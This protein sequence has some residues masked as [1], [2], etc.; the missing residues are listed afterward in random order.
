[1]RITQV[2]STAVILGLLWWHSDSTTPKGLQDQAGLLFFISVFWGFFPVFTAIFTFPQEK[3]MLNKE[4]AVDMY[5]LSAYFMART[6]SDLPL[7]LVLPILFLVIVY[8]MA[9]LR[10]AAAPFLLSMLIVFLSIIAAQGLG[11]A[12]GAIMMD[13]KKATTLGSVTVMAFMLAGGFFVKR[14]PEFI[15]WVRYISFNYHTYRLLLKV[16]YGSHFHDINGIHLDNGVTE[17]GAMI[18]MVF[19]YRFLAYLSLRRMKLQ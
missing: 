19:G 15:S 9:G 14:V 2:F 5:K 11:L 8:F 7:D 16:Q 1:M 17:V 18:I 10:L 3:A 13:V 12:I 6:T 4:R